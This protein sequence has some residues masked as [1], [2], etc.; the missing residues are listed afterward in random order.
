MIVTHETILSACLSCYDR[1]IKRLII[2]LPENRN[3]NGD[4]ET[5]LNIKGITKL[6]DRESHEPCSI[7]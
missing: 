7:K 3:S 4:S 5:N 1:F 6:G 2:I